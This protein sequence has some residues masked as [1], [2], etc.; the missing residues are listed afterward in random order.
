MKRA[1]IIKNTDFKSGGRRVKSG[2]NENGSAIVIALLVMVL[3]MGF[4]ALAISRTSNETVASAN[5]ASETKTFEAAQASLEVMTQNFDKIFDFQLTPSVADLTRI[6]GQHPTGFTTDYDFNQIITKTQI[7][8][9][10]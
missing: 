9:R 4:V 6:E 3:L 2:N 7:A 10:S 5:D 8:N 1:G